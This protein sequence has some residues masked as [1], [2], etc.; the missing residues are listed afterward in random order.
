MLHATNTRR[1]TA[2]TG[3][4][5]GREGR[6]MSGQAGECMWRGDALVGAV[7]G[8]VVGAVVSAQVCPVCAPLHPAVH[9]YPVVHVHA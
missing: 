4:V 2:G 1:T 7:V 9:R 6:R 8:L 5:Q 3:V